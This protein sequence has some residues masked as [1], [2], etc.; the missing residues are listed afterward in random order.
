MDAKKVGGLDSFG[1][2]PT[3]SQVK[4]ERASELGRT[5]VSWFLSLGFCLLISISI[6]AANDIP[7]ANDPGLWWWLPSA[8][9]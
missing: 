3:S 4:L 8:S 6:S 9:A 2:Q 1:E 5:F 7:A